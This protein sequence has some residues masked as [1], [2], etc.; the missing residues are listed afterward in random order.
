M[1][2]LP[3]FG[4]ND[5][6]SLKRC[7]KCPDGQQW[8]PAT[9]AF[10]SRDRSK[11]DGLCNTCKECEKAHSKA[12]WAT[13]HPDDAQTDITVGEGMKRCSK[14]EKVLPAA[15]EFFTRDKNRA[16]GF[17]LQCKECRQQHRNRP[18]V[19]ARK[20]AYNHA[21]YSENRERILAQRKDN[22]HSDPEVR[23][24]ALDYNKR[25]EVREYQRT[26]LQAYNKTPTGK[27]KNRANKHRYR[28]REKSVAGVHTDK[29]IQD[30]L[31]RQKYRCYYCHTKFE[32]KNGQYV[33]NIEHTYPIS[34]VAGTDIPANDISYL[35]LACYP[36]NRDKGDKFPWEWPE[37]GRLL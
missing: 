14:C 11:K 37:G 22:Y 23:Q 18:E 10:F 24:Q 21:Y 26:Y 31:K 20:I 28:A 36:C 17:Y 8:H 32:K 1:D 16:D 33:Y 30:L 3:L 12:R 34:R 2:T 29:Q 5:N 6:P 9:P 25:S 13:Q 15:P 19:R 4:S 27:A 35:V 7:L